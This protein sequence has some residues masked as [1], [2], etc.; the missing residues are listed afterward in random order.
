VQGIFHTLIPV[1]QRRSR[2][3]SSNVEDVISDLL[4]CVGLFFA[5]NDIILWNR[6]FNVLL[7][8]G[9]IVCSLVFCCASS[10]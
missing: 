10:K 9:S 2:N 8:V 1:I 4:L 5:G 7:F 3:R 6:S